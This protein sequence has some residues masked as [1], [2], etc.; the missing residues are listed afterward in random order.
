M[1][2]STLRRMRIVQLPAASVPTFT[3]TVRCQPR[4]V[5]LRATA[6]ARC[7]VLV[8]AVA[9][10]STSPRAPDRM[11]ILVVSRSPSFAGRVKTEPPVTS[12]LSAG[13]TGQGTTVGVGVAVGLGV[14]VGRA[15]ADGVATGVA[16][17]AAGAADAA[18]AG[19]AAKPVA[20]AAVT[21]SAIADRRRSNRRMRLPSPVRPV[22]ATNAPRSWG[23][24]TR[25]RRGPAQA[26][27]RLI[28]HPHNP[29]PVAGRWNGEVGRAPT[30]SGAQR[31]PTFVRFAYARDRANPTNEGK[32]VWL[33]R[34]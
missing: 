30:R 21:A 16:R 24:D 27:T 8:P 9:V 1:V 29:Q 12:A 25:R 31:L 19:D 3:V 26:L 32:P 18:G 28:A 7:T 13:P 34:F 11:R 10:R 23:L 22:H 4:A 17:T 2:W 5:R 6:S 14:A 20:R 33:T 15:V